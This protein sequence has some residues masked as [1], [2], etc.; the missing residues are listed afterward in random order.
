MD[1]NFIKSIEIKPIVIKSNYKYSIKLIR[2]FKYRD[3]YAYFLSRNKLFHYFSNKSSY[4]ISK[5]ISKKSSSKFSLTPSKIIVKKSL[6]ELSLFLN[7]T[8]FNVATLSIIKSKAESL[9]LNN[10]EF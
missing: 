8:A 2:R 1:Y 7:T 6:L 9:L 5:K 3:Y 4:K 10:L